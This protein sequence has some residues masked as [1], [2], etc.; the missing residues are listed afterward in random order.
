MVKTKDINKY[1]EKL[2]K[3]EVWRRSRERKR[4]KDVRKKLI[5]KSANEKTECKI[6]GGERDKDGE[7][8]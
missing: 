3:K 7:S 2:K 4:Q 8:C 6:C 1:G 5:F